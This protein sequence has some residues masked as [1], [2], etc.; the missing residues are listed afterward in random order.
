M[1]FQSRLVSVSLLCFSIT[2]S[3]CITVMF[4]NH[5]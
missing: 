4:F 5:V 1:F 2:F 3:K